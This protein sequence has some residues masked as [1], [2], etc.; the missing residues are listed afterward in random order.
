MRIKSDELF[1]ELYRILKAKGLEEP[2]ARESARLFVETSLDGVYSHGVNRFPRLISYIEKGYID[3][4]AKPT[5]VASIGAFERW[6]G[7]RGMG[8]LN[9]KLCMDR[10]IELSKTYGVGVVALGNTNHWMRGGTY[11]WQAANAGCVGICWTNTMPNMPAWG[12]KDRRI[13]NNPF[14]MSVPRS[15]GQHLVVDMA[16]A[17]FSYGKIEETKLRGEQ[18]PVAGGY[19]SQGQLTTDPVEIEKTWRVLPIGFWKGSGL[20]IALDL[21]AAILSGAYSTT[22]VGKN[23]EDEYAVSQVLIAIDPKHFNS[24]EFTDGIVNRVLA[25]IKASEPV[26]AGGEIRY[27]GEKDYRTRQDN[28]ANGIPV[29][30]DIWAK[31]KALA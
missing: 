10:A 9:A 26:T 28:L 23:C 31:I 6:N 1:N 24:V 12:A 2:D 16:M 29:N 22:D 13:G 7:N 3:I 11:G 14:V 19:D 17:Q 8:N 4:K 27:P 30:P 5:K 18:L 15:N 20:S 25:D 21:I